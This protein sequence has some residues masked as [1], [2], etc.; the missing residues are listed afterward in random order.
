MHEISTT[1]TSTKATLVLGVLLDGS[2]KGYPFVV[3]V[4]VSYTLDVGGVLSVVIRAQNVIKDG[5]P[6]PFMAGCHPY[7]KLAHST[8]KTA[9]VV[10]DN[11]TRWNRQVQLMAQV[12]NG[13]AQPFGGMNGADAIADP[14]VLCPA[15][16]ANAS[17]VPPTLPHRDDGF[18]PTASRL[19][20]PDL[21]ARIH[22]GENDVLYLALD[23]GFR[24]VQVYSGS[25]STGVAVEP[26]SS[27]TD[28][29]NNRDGIIVLED[30]G[31][32]AGRFRIG[33]E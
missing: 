3:Q 33:I 6:A 1:T 12:P 4:N 18:T 24:Y 16:H 21:V 17:T 10:L 5:T 31:V 9:R 2:D 7:F 14:H 20:V 32:W 8:F 29:F 11:R 19:D 25:P 30:G 22:D 28:A 26:M 13:V 27:E 23:D 15:C